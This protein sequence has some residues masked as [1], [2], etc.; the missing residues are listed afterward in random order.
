MVKY[1]SNLFRKIFFNQTI[2]EDRIENN[3][4]K[5]KFKHHIPLFQRLFDGR[6]QFFTLIICVILLIF[7]LIFYLIFFN[8]AK[9]KIHLNQ[10]EPFELPGK[11]NFDGK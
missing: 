5:V 8:P 3:Q 6:E 10:F 4:H 7:A 2:I 11:N 9:K 1:I